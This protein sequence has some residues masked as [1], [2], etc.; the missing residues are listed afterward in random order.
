MVNPKRGEVEVHLGTK[1]IKLCLTFGALVSLEHTLQLHSISELA[2]R[3]SSGR[4]SA[5]DL[6]AILL[7]GLEGSGD[8]MKADEL[9]AL[10]LKDNWPLLIDAVARL[11]IATFGESAADAPSPL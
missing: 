5:N 6:L 10:A 3:I 7:A 8:Q 2:T 11:L 9:K 4:V 1:T